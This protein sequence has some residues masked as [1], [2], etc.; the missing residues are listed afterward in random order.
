M[1]RPWM[2]K[3]QMTTELLKY[4]AVQLAKKWQC[5]KRTIH[6]WAKRHDIK[7][8]KCW[9]ICD[10]EYLKKHAHTMSYPRIAKKLKRSADSVRSMAISLG[11]SIFDHQLEYT[12]LSDLA[13]EFGVEMFMMHHYAYRHKL[14][15]HKL[16]S[17]KIGKLYHVHMTE[18]DEWL[19]AGHILRLNRAALSQRLKSMYDEVSQQYIS[20]TELSA[21]DP[22]LGGYS[23][24][25]QRKRGPIPKPLMI[26]S[27][28]EG[29]YETYYR[30]DEVYAHYFTYGDTI[31]SNIHCEWIDAIRESWGSIYI[32]AS[33]VYK[34]IPRA[35]AHQYHRQ[36]NFPSCH[37]RAYYDR[38]E[39]VAWLE[40]YGW[41]DKAKLIKSDPVTYQELIAYRASRRFTGRYD[42]SWQ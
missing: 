22:W 40:A 23:I 20:Q 17:Y 41:R 38:S 36:K 35:T 13:K 30:K 3:D 16:R 14:P 32:L 7:L 11:I 24:R 4:T 28:S 1:T 27:R 42:T 19:R 31:P 9:P 21:I 39:L 6:M 15:V 10:L 25:C 2:D 18:V 33:D 26:G 34:I 37:Y 12:L 8:H 29:S 5:D